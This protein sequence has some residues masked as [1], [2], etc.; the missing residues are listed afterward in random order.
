MNRRSLLVFGL[1]GLAAV[2]AGALLARMLAAPTVPLESGTWLPEPRKLAD[3]QLNDLDGHAFGA[4]ELQGHPTLVF[5]GFTSCPD[6]CPTTL[7]TLAEVQKAA[8]LPK[9]QVV[10]VTIDPER[11]NAANLRVY[12]NAFS[13]EFI[14]LRADAQAEQPLLHSLGAIAVRQPLPDGSY[15]MDHSAT[16]YVLDSRGRLAAVFSPPFNAGRLTADLRRI[17]ESGRI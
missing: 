14:G 13:H 17:A 9:S 1:I 12:L 16:L 6:V 3:F 10:F 5:F 4:A 15:T 2:I 7:A 11:D 8:P